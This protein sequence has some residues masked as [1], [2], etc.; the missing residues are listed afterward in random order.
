MG[1]IKN[2]DLIKRRKKSIVQ[3]VGVAA[4][5]YVQRA[6]NAELW[7]VEGNRYID[8]AAGIAV[9]NTG[10]CDSRIIEAAKAQLDAFTHTCHQ[11]VPYENYVRLAER[12]N[13][14]APGRFSKKT[15]FV[16]TGA[17]A[18][19]NA[20]KIARYAT[21]RSGVIAFQNA[22]HGR[23]FMGLSLTG[24]VSPYKQGFGPMMPDVFHVP[25]PMEVHG[26]TAEH[27]LAAVEALFRADIHPKNVAAVIFEPIQGEGGFYPAP[28]DFVTGLRR[29]CDRHGI[30]MIVDEVQSGFARTGKMFA[31]EHYDAAGDM[32]VTAKGLAGGLPLAAVTGR[33]DLMDAP[34]P[35]GLGGTFGGNPVSIAAAHAVLDIIEQDSLCN[36]AQQLG[37]LLLSVLNDVRGD[38]P[39][40]TDVRGVGMMSAVEF[41]TAEFT[42]RVKQEAL[43]RSLILLS[44]GSGQNIIRFLAPLTI[45]DAVF[46]EALNIIRD[47]IRAAGQPRPFPGR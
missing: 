46:D 34:P 33:A 37:S 45:E 11:V 13:Q 26:V 27:S 3:G 2:K 47:S 20:V 32:I 22:F 7:D 19:E 31:I 6:K 5:V 40:I 36:R 14:A 16:T 10:H 9:V 44:C 29:L 28:R 12:L 24:K 15:L 30:V 21:G 35:G 43:K 38:V 39:Q 42:A 1:A 41:T 18:A 4:P 25:F 8:F 23:T 17:E